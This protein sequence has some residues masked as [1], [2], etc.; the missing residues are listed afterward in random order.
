MSD[1]HNNIDPAT[2]QERISICIMCVEN[3]QEP[4]PHC[5]LNNIPIS[6][7]T[8]E[9]QETCPLNKW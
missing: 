5:A 6:I 9:E 7:L 3:I 2:Q 4:W 8:S 1:L